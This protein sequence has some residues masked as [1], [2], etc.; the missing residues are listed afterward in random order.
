MAPLLQ[1]EGVSKSYGTNKVLTDVS[2]TLEPGTVTVLIGPSGSGKSSLLRCINGLEPIDSGRILFKGEPLP[3]SDAKIRK[4]R[5]Q[6]GFVFQ[7]FN[8]FPNQTALGNVALAPRIVTGLSRAD[9]EAKAH[10]L[11][12]RVGLADKAQS[13]PD[14]L[15][16]GQ[17]QR[18]SIARALAMSPALMLFDE[19][20]S[21]LD[22]ELTVEVLN[23]MIDLAQSGMTM[24][25]VSHAMSFVKKAATRMIFMREGL[26]VE[27]G[28]TQQMFN[29]PATKA[30][31][32]FLKA[33]E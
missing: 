18:V 6:I 1:L 4:V 20:T 28:T 11:L 3:T 25:V 14:Q 15:S 32:A 19:P 13:Y 9:A 10:E 23:V 17:Q 29:A 5:E 21:A 8:L 30:C 12:T 2:F 27:S 33:I 16:G 7:S 26:I 31:A 24:L 22:P